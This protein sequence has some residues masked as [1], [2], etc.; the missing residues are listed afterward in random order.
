MRVPGEARPAPSPEHRGFAVAAIIL[1]GVVI[2]INS[3]MIAV[4][5]T[6]IARGLGA[7]IGS[8]VWVVT[9]YLV[10][11]AALQPVAGKLGDL[12]GHRRLFLGGVAIFLGASVAAALSPH[13]WALVTF[14][15]L[16]AVGG[17][18]AVP[19]GTATLRGMFSGSQLRH[20]LATVA[21][22]QGL[23]AAVGP[24]L[25]AWLIVLGGWPAI[26]WVNVPIAVTALLLG[27]RFLPVVG[28]RQRRPL[29]WFGALILAGMLALLSLAIPRGGEGRSLLTV[30]LLA[31]AVTGFVFWERRAPEPVVRLGWFVRSGFRSANLA[32]LCSNFFMYS[33]LLFMP[34]YLRARGGSAAA[35]VHL[36]V[37]SLASS[38]VAFAGGHIT[39]AFGPR[40]AVGAAFFLDLIV[41]AWYLGLS[42]G[43]T[44]PYV[45][46]GL[47]VAGIGAGI[48]TVAMQTTL[49]E[50]VGP[51]AAGAA[52]GIYSTFRYIGSISA[53]ALLSV[54]VAEPVLHWGVLLAVALLGLAIVPGF[55]PARP[56]A[57]SA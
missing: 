37:F 21:T 36:F 7:A 51:E 25:G 43:A 5:L 56:L 47:L 38:L 39:R 11:M 48:G 28:A 23:G 45:W 40:V 53:S 31:V 55:S 41:V 19:N 16:Q 30:P 15:S 42:Q 14:R 1:G 29:D 46:G 57:T 4:G 34:I 20:T 9:A 33:T 10:V 13:L 44:S 18:L 27:L 52:S 6:P 26:F 12:F 24:L 3:T 32:I 49:L 50:S 8:V 35:G 22:I 54:M 2:P 17:A